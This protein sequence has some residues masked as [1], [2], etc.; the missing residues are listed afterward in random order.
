MEV[1]PDSDLQ[2]HVNTPAEQA[3]YAGHIAQDSLAA[4]HPDGRPVLRPG[5]VDAYRFMTFYLEPATENFEDFFNKVIDPIWLAQS[6]DPDAMALR[7]AQQVE[8]KPRCW[9]ILHR[10]TF[11][12]RIL[13]DFAPDAQPATVEEAMQVADVQSN[14]ALIKK[15]EPFVRT[16][17]ESYSASPV[18][19][20]KRSP[21]TCRSCCRTPK[22]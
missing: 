19:W 17:T 7:Q 18:P 2:L 9:R 10:V 8:K 15:L 5:R 16:K 1:A 12:S 4:W 20:S 22:R 3:K 11:V 14:W 6:D 21:R 13:P